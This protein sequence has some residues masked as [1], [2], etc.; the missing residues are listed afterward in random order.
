MRFNMFFVRYFYG[1]RALVRLFY[2][3]AEPNVLVLRHRKRTASQCDNG[4]GVQS[5]GSNKLVRQLSPDLAG[6]GKAFLFS[7]V[8]VLVL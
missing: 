8:A 1:F 7:L 4:F 3:V 5:R 6:R 2:D